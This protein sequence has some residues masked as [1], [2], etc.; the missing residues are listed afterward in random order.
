MGYALYSE[1]SE[2]GWCAYRGAP[3]LILQTQ[4]LDL[5]ITCT[6]VKTVHYLLVGVLAAVQ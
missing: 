4:P 2:I 5:S 6:G 3:A 1:P